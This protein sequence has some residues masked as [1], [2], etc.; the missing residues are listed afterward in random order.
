MCGGRELSAAPAVAGAARI[1]EGA[2]RRL[3]ERT[4]Q[5]GGAQA[6]VV[7]GVRDQVVVG[8][9]VGSGDDRR[10]MLRQRKRGGDTCGD[11]GK[12]AVA[13]MEVVRVK[14]DSH[15]EAQGDRAES[16]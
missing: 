3:L 5:T 1:W 2:V 12:A 14:R 13:A 11:V 15:R 8:V 10:D 7:G 16:G 9:V 6:E 4:G